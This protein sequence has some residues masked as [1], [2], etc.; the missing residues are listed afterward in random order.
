MARNA[1]SV[2]ESSTAIVPSTGR[3]ELA[4]AAP[5]ELRANPYAEMYLSGLPSKDSRPAQRSALAAIARMMTGL[6]ASVCDIHNFPWTA[7]TIVHLRTLKAI[8]G[9]TYQPR[10]LN[11]M[12]A[13]VKGVLRVCWEAKAMD[14]DQYMRAISIRG[15]S[16]KDLEPAGRAISKHEV[17]QLFRAAAKAGA[18][19]L[20]YQALLVVLYVG[21]LRRQEASAL[22]VV[23]VDP[24]TGQI[25]VRRGKRKKFRET[26]VAAGYRPWIAPWLALQRERGG[27]PMF[28]RWDRKTDSPSTR[29]LSRVGVDDVLREITTL[30]GV[31]DVTP[32]DLRRSMATDL[33]EAGADLLMVQQLLGHADVKT[34]SIYDRRGEAGKKSAAEKLPVVLRYEDREA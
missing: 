34:T 30:A 7:I 21:G 26:Y 17:Q 28:V 15:M 32:H 13:A 22:D 4:T 1:A 29:R 20:Q 24:M 33:L 27:G 23:N 31:A 16:T 11:R 18:R 3:G 9:E 10:S 12:L 6:D 14:T 25:T 8:I 19:G 2:T 5:F